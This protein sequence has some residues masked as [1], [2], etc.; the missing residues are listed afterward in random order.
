MKPCKQKFLDI[1]DKRALEKAI[2]C[3]IKSTLHCTYALMKNLHVHT[4]DKLKYVESIYLVQN[5]R[6]TKS[7]KYSLT[8]IR[9]YLSQKKSICA[10]ERPDFRLALRAC[11]RRKISRMIFKQFACSGE[12]FLR[13]YFLQSS[14]ISSDC[15]ILCLVCMVTIG[16]T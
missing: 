2:D 12:R 7:D 16:N 1:F 13:E 5:R 10:S 4:S 3:L 14:R 8:I 15:F 6:I 9:E 11:F